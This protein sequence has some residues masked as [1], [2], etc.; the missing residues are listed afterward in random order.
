MLTKKGAAT[1]QRII[2]AAADEIRDHGAGAATL[3]DICRR[4]GTGKSQLFHYFPEGKEQLLLAVAEWEAGQVIE[5]QQPYLGRLTTWEAWEKWRDVVVRRYRR[6]GVHCPL[7]VLITEIG[8]HTPAA[9]A[10]TRQLLEQW[11]RQVQA[12]IEDMRE[13]GDIGRDVDPVRASAALIAAIQGGVT[14]LMSTG[15]ADHL[16][17]ALDLYLDYLRGG[18][19]VPG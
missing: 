14:I 5:D 12:G 13:S 9:Q 10:V 19:P 4:S 17:A 15:S 1:R 8:R 3:D 16:E 18:V 6:Q 7:G 11:Q 2:E